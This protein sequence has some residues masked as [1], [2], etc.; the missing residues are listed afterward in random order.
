MN[1]NFYNQAKGF[2]QKVSPTYRTNLRLEQKL[3][4]L[5][6]DLEM[7]IATEGTGRSS[8]HPIA[9]AVEKELWDS[10]TLTSNINLSIACAALEIHETHK[11][12]FSEFYRCHTGK[13]IA[14]VAAGPSLQ[15]Y[16]NR[17]Q[18]PHIGV[19]AV[20][21]REDIPLD[22]YF[23]TDYEGKNKWFQDLKKHD[24]IKF[25]GQYSSGEYRERFQIPEYIIEENHGRRY[26]QGAPSEDIHLNIEYYPLMGFYSVVFQAIHFALYTNAKRIFLIG[27]DCTSDGY[28]DGSRQASATPEKWRSGYEK[29]KIFAERFYPDSEIVSLNPVGLK[30][31]F[32]DIYTDEFTNKNN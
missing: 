13:D 28:F 7:P 1:R 10:R 18:I 24:F 32:R 6:R 14:V 8:F 21:K 25:F 16:K 20:F 2:L 12:S 31:L 30:G 5:L 4:R 17:M 27:C 9:S 22:Y 19:N 29:V 26:F 11:E 15:Y 23:V 3:D